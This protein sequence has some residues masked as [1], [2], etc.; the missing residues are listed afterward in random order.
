MLNILIFIFG[1]LIG[2]FLN[3]VIYRLPAGKSIVFPRSQ[4]SQCQTKLGAR[5]LIPVVSYLLLGGRCRYCKSRFSLQYPVVELLTGLLFLLLYQQYSLSSQFLV[6]SF[7]LI[8]LI[9]ASVIDFKQQIIPN[10]INYFGIGVG[11]IFNLLFDHISLASSLLGIVIA[12]GALFLLAVVSG[13]MGMGDVKFLAMIGSFLGARLALF[14]LF[15]GSL[16]GAVVL[17]PLLI[18]GVKDRKDRIA[19]GP[20]IALGAVLMILGGEQIIAWYLNLFRFN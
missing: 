20:L 19:F 9:P 18:A 15:F 7:L 1:L 16:I 11:L 5:D 10:Q 6:Y 4:C 8:L 13:D 17:V 12:G 14:S 2:S 3:V